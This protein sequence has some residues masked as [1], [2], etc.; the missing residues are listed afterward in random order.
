LAIIKLS[1]ELLVEE[2]SIGVLFF[3]KPH[4][5]KASDHLQIRLAFL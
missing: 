1:T 3:D 5:Q 4:M 2:P